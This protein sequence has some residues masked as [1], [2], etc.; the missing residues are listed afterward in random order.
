[1]HGIDYV[2]TRHNSIAPHPN[3][4]C[5]D[6]ER[7]YRRGLASQSVPATKK[8]QAGIEEP[9][10][11]RKGSICHTQIASNSHMQLDDTVD[12]QMRAAPA[13]GFDTVGTW[14]PAG[15]F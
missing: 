8:N 7:T 10:S 2:H 12:R 6:I 9:D 11:L 3:L 13:I 5:A 1:M 4:P 14:L 15:W